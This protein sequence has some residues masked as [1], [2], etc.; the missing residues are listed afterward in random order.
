MIAYL[1]GTIIVKNPNYIILKCSS[2]GYKIFIVPT[3]HYKKGE[4]ISLYIHEHITEDKDDLYGFKTLEKMEIF[5]LLLSV[6]GLGPKIGM[7][8]LSSMSKNEIEKSIESGDVKSFKRIKGIGQ[9]MA[10]KIILE[11]KTKLDIIEL[12]KLQGDKKVDT[13][14]EEVL[15]SLGYKQKEISKLISQIPNDISN[16]E[17]KIKWVL[18]NI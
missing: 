1:E 3:E 16:L 12:D 6:S 14:V 5:E 17:S 11:L 9:K 2:I 8:I 13:E 10:M 18:K 7:T 4:D 15:I